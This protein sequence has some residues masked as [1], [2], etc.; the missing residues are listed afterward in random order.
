MK[1]QR[2]L[3][4]NSRHIYDE[5][6]SYE[7]LFKM[8]KT[9][10]K[11]CKNKPLLM[12]FSLNLHANLGKI[13]QELKTRSYRPHRFRTFMIFEPK[14]RLVMSQLIRDK[15]VNHFVANF[16]LLPLLEDCLIDQNVATRKGFGSA[17]AMRQLKAYFASILA[18]HPG[19]KVYALKVDVS[20]YFYSIEH[21]KL[22]RMLRK[23]ILDKDVLWLIKLL[24]DETDKPYINRSIQKFNR[25]FSTDIPEYRRGRGLSIGAMAS[26]F[27]AIYFLNELD[28]KIKEELRCR[29]YLRYMDDL[30]VLSTD[31]NELRKILDWL[32]VE[33]EKLGLTVNPKSRIYN[34]ADGF[35][36]LGFRYRI[37]E[38][39]L[40]VSCAGATVR[41]IYQRI[42]LKRGDFFDGPMSMGREEFRQMIASYCGYFGCCGRAGLARLE[43]MVRVEVVET[44]SYPWEG[45]II[46]VIRHPQ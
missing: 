42:L 25:R 2:R 40:Q 34:C 3:Q 24:I 37:V 22:M 20:K 32:T 39:R 13:E 41:R 18:K 8:W 23:K 29:Y 35:V 6:V 14:P 7:N 4:K 5:A 11:T 21:E 17:E 16:F 45:Y 33:L 15:I 43:G 28:H 1:K 19:Q 44:S 26:Q 9:V 36:F 12:A 30:L 38:G 31:K 10:R 27:L 46:A